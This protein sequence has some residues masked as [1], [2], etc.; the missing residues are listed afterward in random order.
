MVEMAFTLPLLGLV[1]L[2]VMNLGLTVREHQLLQN[3]AREGARFS[4]LPENRLAPPGSPSA[5]VGNIKQRVV[6]YCAEEKIAVNA[7]DITLTQTYPIPV[8]GG[9]TA[10]GSEVTVSHNRQMLFLGLPILPTR[11]VR[12]TGRAVFR[13]LY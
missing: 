10:F 6:D 8:S 4:S 12:L 11:T 1:F 9:L 13:N 2:I 3:A 7:A 5:S